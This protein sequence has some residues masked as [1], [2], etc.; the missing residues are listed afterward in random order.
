M[1]GQNVRIVSGTLLTQPSNDSRLAV[2]TRGLAAF[3]AVNHWA[4]KPSTMTAVQTSADVRGMTRRTTWT[5]ISAR[6]TPPVG[7]VSVV[8]RSS[9]A[10]ATVDGQRTDVPRAG[11]ASASVATYRSSM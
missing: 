6:K 9:S 10:I 1:P 2:I 5:R 8:S 4:I 7:I 11:K 3:D